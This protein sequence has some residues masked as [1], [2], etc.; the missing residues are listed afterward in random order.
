[1]PKA[2]QRAATSRPIRP[3]PTTPTRL[4]W[5]STPAKDFRSHF[6]ALMEASAWAM[7]RAI[8]MR[9]A[10]ASSAVETRFPPGEFI[11]TMPRAGGGGQVHVV[12]PDA[13]AGR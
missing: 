9:R 4:P 3:R 13:R 2:W 7:F 6:W 8:A 5:S 12:D 10:K 1:M 11:T